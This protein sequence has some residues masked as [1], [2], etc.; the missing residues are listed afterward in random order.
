MYCKNVICKK[1][2]KASILHI[3]V[4]RKWYLIPSHK[5]MTCVLFISAPHPPV[6]SS[7]L[8]VYTDMFCRYVPTLACHCSATVNRQFMCRPYTLLS[9]LCTSIYTTVYWVY[10][11]LHYCLLCVQPYTLFFT[12]CKVVYTNLYCVYSHTYYSLL[13]TGVYTIGSCVQLCTLLYTVCTA[14]TWRLL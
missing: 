14:T 4:C 7:N 11:H 13:C 8:A 9:T 2:L 3:L 1:R 12:G 5:I 10:S 6:P